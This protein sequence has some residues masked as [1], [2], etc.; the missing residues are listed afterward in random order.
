M[1]KKRNVLKGRL[2]E[3]DLLLSSLKSPDE[4]LEIIGVSG[5]GGVGKTY[6]VRH[7]LE[8]LE[9]EKSGSLVIWVDGGAKDLNGDFM[10]LVNESLAP[11]QLKGVPDSSGHDFFPRTRKLKKAHDIQVERVIRKIEK[12][13]EQRKQEASAQTEKIVGMLLK[14]GVIFNTPVQPFALALAAMATD[15]LAG[16]AAALIVEAADEPSR[17]PGILQDWFGITYDRKIR[18][19]LFNLTAEE[20][21]GDLTAILSG[22]G[23]K[24]ILKLTHNKLQGFDRLLLVIDD[25]EIINQ[26]ILPFLL[27]SF[28][29]SLKSAAFS[30]KV[31]IIGRDN[32]EFV[33][34][35]F[36]KDFGRNLTPSIRLEPFPPDEAVQFLLDADYSKTEA[37]ELVRQFEGY[38]FLL[39]SLAEMKDRSALFYQHFFERTTRWMTDDEK[40][41]FLSLCYLD[42]VNETS[43]AGMIEGA[44]LRTIC[45]WFAHEASIRD[46]KAS[47]FV[48]NPFIRKM[49]LQH[50]QNLI[51]KRE[52]SKLQERGKISVSEAE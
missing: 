25:F 30:S 49:V 9:P 6:L 40:R 10:R 31:L 18:T 26:T 38:P 12:T 14:L 19:Q 5:Y 4:G 33:D 24:D 41:W 45:D 28:L 37:Q 23:K 16:E 7:V 50:H 2:N 48:V 39:V 36:S 15:K 8:E 21:T 35:G 17:L 34:P 46:N 3:R 13:L 51:G 20:L 52:Q 32:L 11:L 47:H 22:Y 42:V 27:N 29:P 43:I 44:E 1:A